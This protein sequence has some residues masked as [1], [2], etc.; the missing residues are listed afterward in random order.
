MKTSRVIGAAAGAVLK[1][2]VAA[3]L[4]AGIYKVSLTAYDYGYRIFGEP[5]ISEG[6]GRTVTVTIPEGKS[7]TEIGEILVERG[8]LRDAKLFSIQEKVSTYKDKL[9]PG[10]YEL[11]TSMTAEEMMAIMAENPEAAADEDMEP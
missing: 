4:I 11:S 3:I 2:A 5:P 7:V 10:I 6:E 8:L 1:A 9:R